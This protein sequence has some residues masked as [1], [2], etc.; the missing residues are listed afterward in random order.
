MSI[1]P[2]QASDRETWTLQALKNGAQSLLR[3][4]RADV[5]TDLVTAETTSLPPLGRWTKRAVQREVRK[6]RVTAPLPAR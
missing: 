5:Y 1:M 2:G 4:L 6:R 3:R